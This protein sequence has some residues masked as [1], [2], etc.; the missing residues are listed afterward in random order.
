MHLQQSELAALPR[1]M[2][3]ELDKA[4]VLE[5]LLAQI[6]TVRHRKMPVVDHLPH[7]DSR[8]GLL[9]HS[10]LSLIVIRSQAM[11]D[12]PTTNGNFSLMQQLPTH[13]LPAQ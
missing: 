2:L 8:I 3:K 9:H 13:M 7:L 4:S 11:L 5:F 6:Q 10:H 1:E 12:Q